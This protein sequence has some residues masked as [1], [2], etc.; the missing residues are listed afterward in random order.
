MDQV[1]GTSKIAG[2]SFSI[3]P[4]SDE[5]AG[6][7]LEILKKVDTSK[8]WLDTDD[9]TTTVRGRV[10]HIFDVTKAILLHVSK[11]NVHAA[12][13]A[14]YSIG[15]PGDSAGDT[16]MAESL[17]R[18]NED[19]SRSITQPLAAK[20]SLYPMGGGSYMDTIYKQIEAM[21][22]KGIQVTPAHYSTRLDGDTH[23]VF[24][25]LENVFRETEASGSSHTVMTVS[26]SV[27]SPSSK[28]SIL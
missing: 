24:E 4:M 28:E 27:N 10:E 7:I 23:T 15:C 14:T 3:H 5:F 21:K 25:G 11:T 26:V 17:H 2:C 12:F 22:S 8:V 9:V 19:A 18:R 13:H 1:C 6:I 20:F 16:Y